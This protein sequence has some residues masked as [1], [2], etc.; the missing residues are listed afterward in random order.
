VTWTKLGDDF[1]EN[2]AMRR[3]SR[4]ARYLRVEALVWCNRFGTDGNVEADDLRW[5]TDSPD[6]E[7][8]AA[9]LVEAGLWTETGTG[10][11]VDWTD[12][13][14]AEEIAKERAGHAERNRRYLRRGRLHQAGDHS[15]CTDSC[16]ARKKG[17]ASHD[18][19]ADGSHDS[20]PS[21]SVPSRPK[22]GKGKGEG[23]G[24]ATPLEEEQTI[25]AIKY[26]AGLSWK[27]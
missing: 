10:W 24:A 20:P 18:A 2:P 12:Q 3:L 27:D 5:I 9:E 15:E 19:S 21:L 25:P 8:A 17:D 4:D 1:T 23:T 26:G 11:Q 6:P 7:K 13:F 16:R 14:T 22:G